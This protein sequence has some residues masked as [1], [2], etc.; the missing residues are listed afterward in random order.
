MLKSLRLQ[1]ALAFVNPAYNYADIGADHGYLAAAILDLGSSFVQVVENKDGPL[2][3]AKTNLQDYDNVGFT[4]A[5]GLTQIDPKVNAVTICGMGGLNIVGI[6]DDELLLAKSFKQLILEPNSKIHELRTYLSN[7]HFVILGEKIVYE[8][9]K[10]Y[11][12]NACRY[13]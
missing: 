11:E 13:D 5:D 6:I 3:H 10:Y 4:L 7:H 1:G 9:G 2:A 8:Q 12:I